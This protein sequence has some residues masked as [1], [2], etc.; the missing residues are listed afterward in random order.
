MTIGMQYCLKRHSSQGPQKL[1]LAKAL[2][3]ARG[4]VLPRWGLNAVSSR[5]SI[6]LII[7]RTLSG[8]AHATSLASNGSSGGVT[9][10]SDNASQ[11]DC[12][13]H[14]S[15]VQRSAVQQQK[16]A[17]PVRKT[18]PTAEERGSGE[19]RKGIAQTEQV[20]EAATAWTSAAVLRELWR[21]AHPQD[22]GKRAGKIMSIVCD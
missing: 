9:T 8:N 10:V 2:S 12:F 6:W 21:L 11:A 13:N 5:A 16:N 7:V 20:E 3:H 19:Q 22:S 14:T 18:T 4:S 1:P 17:N 15:A